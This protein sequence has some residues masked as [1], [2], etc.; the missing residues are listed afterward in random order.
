MFHRLC[1]HLFLLNKGGLSM[2]LA[3]LLYSFCLILVCL[4]VYSTKS[5]NNSLKSRLQ[6]LQTAGD[7]NREMMNPDGTEQVNLTNHPADDLHSPVWSPT[8][9]QI[10][11]VSDRRR[12]RDL[13]LMDANGGNVRRI[14]TKHE[15][16][17]R[18]AL[19]TRW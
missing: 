2:N 9:E 5:T 8:G 16:R 3:R 12:G 7:V 15:Y 19:V 13:Y 17:T 18:P 6:R 11:F 10:L 14:F 1:I 4:S